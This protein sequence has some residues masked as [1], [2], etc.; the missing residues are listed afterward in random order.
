[1][2]CELIQ[3]ELLDYS[4]GLLNRSEAEVVR[5]HLETCTTC[6]ALLDEEVGFSTWLSSVPDEQP[7]NDVWALVRTKTRPRKYSPAYLLRGLVSQ[8][9][10]RTL[11]FAGV[12][13]AVAAIFYVTMP[14][15]S[16]P[17]P[18]DRPEAIAS[19]V[20]PLADEPLADHADAVIDVI[21]GM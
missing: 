6:R 13:G 4:K 11:A 15:V 3:P 7:E 12:L 18:V 20:V 21:E 10:R 8:Q 19:A 9:V 2:K 5:V 16:E 1:M 14:V 17:T